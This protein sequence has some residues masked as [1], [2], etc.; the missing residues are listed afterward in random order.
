[1][2]NFLAL[3]GMT[4]LALVVTVAVYGGRSKSYPQFNV[5]WDAEGLPVLIISWFVL[6]GIF[7][8]L[9]WLR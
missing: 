5:W 2:R 3:A 6:G 4:L 1:M 8:G 9:G 7:L